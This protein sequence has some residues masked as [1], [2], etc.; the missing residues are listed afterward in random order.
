M[1]SC[2][3]LSGYFSLN[4][5]LTIVTVVVVKPAIAYSAGEQIALARGGKEIKRRL[6]LGGWATTTPHSLIE[7]A[8]SRNCVNEAYLRRSQTESR[9]KNSETWLANSISDDTRRVAHNVSPGS[10]RELAWCLNWSVVAV[11]GLLQALINI[12]NRFTSKDFN[13]TSNEPIETH[14]M[15][16]NISRNCSRS[17]NLYHMSTVF[18]GFLRPTQRAFQSP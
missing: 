16:H 18:S 15:S 6:T 4:T 1:Q 3:M 5:I 9:A 7:R 13:D 10:W 2:A 11:F 14:Y 12:R 8:G 17:P